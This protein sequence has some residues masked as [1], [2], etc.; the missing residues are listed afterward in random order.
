MVRR[1]IGFPL[2]CA[3]VLGLPG[4]ALGF[5][6]ARC[7]GIAESTP[8]GGAEITHESG[9]HDYPSAAPP[10]GIERISG[11]VAINPMMG[12]ARKD[13]RLEPRLAMLAAE[14]QTMG[15]SVW[16]AVLLRHSALGQLQ[17]E[18]VHQRP[19]GGAGAEV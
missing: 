10:P 1:I 19:V 16:R 7:R 3:T 8:S 17:V 13:W 9:R 15:K 4:T 18:F 2:V 11:R 12:I 5:H 6:P 14:P